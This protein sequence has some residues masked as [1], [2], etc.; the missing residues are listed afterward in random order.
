[1]HYALSPE[2]AGQIKFIF[3]LFLLSENTWVISNICA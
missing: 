1:M 2:H 3:F